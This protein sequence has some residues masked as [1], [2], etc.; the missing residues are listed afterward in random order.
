MRCW[1][2]NKSWTSKRPEFGYRHFVAVNYGG[3]GINRWVGLISVL[4]GNSRFKVSWSELNDDSKWLTGWE[5]LSRDE[6]NPK[7]EDLDLDQ[8]VKNSNRLQDVCLH[9]SLDSGLLIPCTSQNQ[10]PWIEC[11]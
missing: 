11:N 10:R 8:D 1:P 3:K 7:I 9:P 2:P 6:A 4:N 5:K